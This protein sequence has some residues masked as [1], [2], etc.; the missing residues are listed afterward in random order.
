MRD[1]EPK[2]DEDD[3]FDAGGLGLGEEKGVGR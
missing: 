1:E 3:G 2:A